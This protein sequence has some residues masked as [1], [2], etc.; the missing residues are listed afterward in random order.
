[1]TPTITGKSANKF[2]RKM[3][4]TEKR[5]ITKK[6]KEIV[7]NL[8]KAEWKHC[9]DLVGKEAKDNYDLGYNRGRA[10]VLKEVYERLNRF[11][12]EDMFWSETV[13]DWI[14]NAE[15]WIELLKEFG[16]AQQQEVSK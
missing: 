2:A 14:V 13:D 3:L 5:P 16:K 15:D 11:K 12:K 8:T 6:E 10:E 1:M 7:D 9:F 4:E